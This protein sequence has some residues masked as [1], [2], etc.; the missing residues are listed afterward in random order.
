MELI[1]YY[2]SPFARRVGI[3]LHLYGIPFTHRP[4]GPRP[5]PEEVRARNPLGRIPSLVLDSGEVLIDSLM[6]I[7]FLDELAG[8]QRALIPASGERRWQVNRLVALA[9]GT[10]EKSIAVFY[11]RIRRPPSHV[12]QP[13]LDKLE[14]QCLDGLAALEAALA[15]RTHAGPWLLPGDMTHADVAAAV[16]L[17]GINFDLPGLVPP[18]RFSRLEALSAEAAV[19]PAFAAAVP[20]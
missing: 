11:E 16:A 19:L 18:G 3:T 10:A 2:A 4:F 6:I 1:G 5:D 9:H 15:A 12:W 13:W 17:Q 8:P 7:D 14:S 20:A